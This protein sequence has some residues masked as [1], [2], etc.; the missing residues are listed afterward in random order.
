MNEIYI[1][2]GTAVL[3][4]GLNQFIFLYQEKHKNKFKLNEFKFQKYHEKQYEKIE[5]L[6][7]CYGEYS[8]FFLSNNIFE[9][10]NIEMNKYCV[11]LNNL[12]NKIFISINKYN[13]YILKEDLTILIDNLRKITIVIDDFKT[14]F[15]NY[16]KKSTKSKIN[17]LSTES[18]D[19][20]D[21]VNNM[22][23][24]SV[25]IFKKYLK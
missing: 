17:K 15:K 18:L 24:E 11:D 7:E 8:N 21:Q 23:F 3:T 13:F 10:N 14:N 19:L 20:F 1:I 9:F 6:C 25:K 22:A 4:T 5:E 16:S 12:T 2:I